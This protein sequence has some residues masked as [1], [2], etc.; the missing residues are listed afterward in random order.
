M[1]V[2]AFVQH[3]ADLPDPRI[4]RCKHHA[5]LDMLIIAF[6]SVLCGAEGWE[7]MQQFGLAKRRW[8]KQRLGLTLSGGILSDDTFRRFFTRL[9]PT[10]FER[11]FRAW[12]ERF[13]ITGRSSTVCT[14]SWMWAWGRMPVVSV[15]TTLL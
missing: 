5:L 2:P 3:F 10:A 14:M 1:P 13:G 4:N 8:L 15:G 9:D 12:V 7:E 11:C 6:L